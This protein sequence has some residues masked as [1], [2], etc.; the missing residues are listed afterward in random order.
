MSR[1]NSN[2]VLVYAPSSQDLNLILK[3]DIFQSFLDFFSIK[4]NVYF[5][6]ISITQLGGIRYL[7]DELSEKYPEFVWLERRS[8]EGGYKKDYITKNK[9]QHQIDVHFDLIPRQN[10]I[11]INE[12]IG[13]RQWQS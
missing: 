8:G 10:Y 6:E 9:E 4:G 13:A 12:Y 5:F 1:Y 11:Q 2:Y 3:E 7:S